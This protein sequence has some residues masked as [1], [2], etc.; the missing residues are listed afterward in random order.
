MFLIC[1]NDKWHKGSSA[2]ILTED[3][4]LNNITDRTVMV[5]LP[6][7]EIWAF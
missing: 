1:F 5:V 6:G 4:P 2:H 7:E 3:S